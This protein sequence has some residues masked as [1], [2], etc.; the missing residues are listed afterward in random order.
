MLRPEFQRLQKEGATQLC[1]MSS[2]EETVIVQ[3]YNI[4]LNKKGKI[5]C[6]V[7]D[8]LHCLKAIIQEEKIINPGIPRLYSEKH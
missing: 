3:V 2:D 8:G 1:Q 4:G 5:T 6:F 7:S